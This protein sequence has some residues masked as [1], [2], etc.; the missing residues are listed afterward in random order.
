MPTIG[1][2]N[3]AGSLG[4]MCESAT[5]PPVDVPIA[6]HANPP[7]ADVV[8]GRGRGGGWGGGTGAAPCSVNDTRAMRTEP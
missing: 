3:D 5:G 2:G 7:V 6:T 4:K 1:S 8:S